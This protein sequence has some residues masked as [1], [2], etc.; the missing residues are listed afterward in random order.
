MK[1]Y[2]QFPA[3]EGTDA[4]TPE[5]LEKIAAR[6]EEIARAKGTEADQHPDIDM[7]T[8]SY[9]G[10]QA[11]GIAAHMRRHGMI[12]S[13]NI[14]CF[15]LDFFEKGDIVRLRK[16]TR[17]RSMKSRDDEIVGRTYSITVHRADQGFTDNLHKEHKSV[18]TKPKI[19]WAG[20]GGYWCYVDI[21]DVELV[22]RA[23]DQLKTA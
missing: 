7:W 8:A 5:S 14:G 15:Q 21:D 4:F 3:I 11:A 13:R 22:S 16:G 12:E 17:Y 6:W 23:A 2:Q 9:R 19:V 20:A 10:E 1:L 18:V